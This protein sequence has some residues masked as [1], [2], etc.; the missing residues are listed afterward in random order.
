MADS[1]TPKRKAGSSTLPGDTKS[2][3]RLDF[4]LCGAFLFLPFVFADGIGSASALPCKRKKDA[5]QY[6]TVG[7]THNGDRAPKRL[8]LLW[9]Q[10]LLAY[11]IVIRQPD[12]SAVAAGDD[13]G[14]FF[15]QIV[16]IPRDRVRRNAKLVGEMPHGLVSPEAET[17]DQQLSPF[18]WPH[19]K[20]PLSLCC[21]A[22]LLIRFVKDGTGSPRTAMQKYSNDRAVMAAYGFDVKTTTEATCVAALMKRYQTLTAP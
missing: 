22:F 6:F 4:R 10:M 7:S 8:C 15:F 5:F 1:V 3:A 20:L 21:G 18:V 12:P 19:C 11:I 9:R 16:H 13:N 2:A 17:F 14:V